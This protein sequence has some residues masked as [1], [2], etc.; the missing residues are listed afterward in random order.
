MQIFEISQKG[1]ARRVYSFV[2][3]L[4]SKIFRHTVLVSILQFLV[5]GYGDVTY[6]SRRNLLGAMAVG[7]DIDYHLFMISANSPNA[8]NSAAKLCRKA[9]SYNQYRESECRYN[10][11]LLDVVS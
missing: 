3:T 5:T 6:N 8:S 10:L 7:T 2:E 11:F 9:K 1:R 4:G